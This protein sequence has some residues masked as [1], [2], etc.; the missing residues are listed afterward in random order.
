MFKTGG[1]AIAKGNATKPT[2]T[3]IQ[4]PLIK[5]MTMRKNKFYYLAM[6][7]MAI[8]ATTAHAQ[9]SVA[10]VPDG[11]ITFTLTKGQTSYLSL[12]L[13][14]HSTYT[15]VVTAVTTNTVSVDDTPAPF[16]TSLATPA[17]PYFIKFLSGNES[18]RVM[19]ITANTAST[20]TVDTTDHTSGAAVA[21]TTTSFNVQVGDTFEVFPG[22]TIASVFGEGTSDSPLLLTGA[23]NA[24]LSDT[25][26]LY[27]TVGSA[28]KIYYYNTIAGYWEQY[29][30]TANANN[31]IIYPYSAFSIIRRSP[32]PTMTLV[33]EGRVTQVQAATKV[34][35][36]GTVYT[37]SHYATNIKLSQLQ[38]GS[39]WK[40]GT[41]ATTADTISVWNATEGKFVTFYQKPDATWRLSSDAKTDQ[42]SFEIAA[43]TVTTIAKHEAVSGA[44]SFLQSGMPYSLN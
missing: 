40:T 37:S 39:N 15:S 16:T 8:G 20:L 17:S 13:T 2:Q 36:Q 19:L 34:V 25:V 27:T 35:S 4:K 12:P 21:L 22:D 1:M 30:T 31:T 24:S 42:S 6:I 11:L 23:Q 14:N 5:L 33:L 18:G 32:H 9:T 7:V 38:F 10:T 44:G 28:A 3:K 43:G 29:G 26:S 41:S